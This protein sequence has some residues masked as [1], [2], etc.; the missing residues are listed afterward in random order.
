MQASRAPL[1]RCNPSHDW[2]HRPPIFRLLP[3]YVF[4][5]VA[6]RVQHPQGKKNTKDKL[7]FTAGHPLR[8]THKLAIRPRGELVLPRLLRNPPLRPPDEDEPD[9]DKTEAENRERFAAF[10][11]GI[12]TTEAERDAPDL[13]GSRTLWEMLKRWESA[14]TECPIRRCCRQI[15]QNMATRAAIIEDQKKQGGLRIVDQRKAERIVA[16]VAAAGVGAGR[17]PAV[18]FE[19]LVSDSDDDSDA[20]RDD[21]AISG[22]DDDDWGEMPDPEHPSMPSNEHADVAVAFEKMEEAARDRNFRDKCELPRHPSLS[23]A[24]LS[25]PR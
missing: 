24:D 21:D 22:D 2:E 17:Q 11:L 14:P 18:D 19:G 7:A 25:A 13:R 3:P 9:N 23:L 6:R 10:V 1:V 4:H 12:F 20:S 5:M 8:A 15:A 16:S